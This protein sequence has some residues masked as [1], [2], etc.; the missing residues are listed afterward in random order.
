M[1]AE[2]RPTLLSVRDLKTYFIQDEGTVKAVDGVSF[3]LYPGATL[4]IVGESGC[5]KSVTARSILGIVDRPGRIVSGEIRFRRQA[6]ARTAEPAV[7]LAKLAPDGPEIRAIRGA[8]IAL[9]FQEPMSSFSPVHTIGSQIVEVIMLHQRINRGEARQKAIEILRRVGVSSPEQRVDQ[10]SNQLSGGLRQRAMIAMALSCHPT[11]LIADEPTTA[12]DVTTQTQILELLRQLQRE[13]G[14]A[15]MLI[16]HD[17]G[18]V[19]EMATDVAV[20]YLGRVVEQGTVDQIFHDPEAPVYPGPPPVHPPHALEIAGAADAHRGRGAAPLRPAERLP[21]PPAL[22]GVHGGALRQGGA[23]AAAGRGQARGQLLPLPVNALAPEVLLRVTGLQKLF[24]IRKGFLRRT[25]G[26]VR[27]VD[28]VDFHIDEGETLGL[29]GES[30]CGK[31]TTARCIMRA[32]E[33]TGGEILMRVTDGSVVEVGRLG[34]K[35]LRALRREMQMIFQ[36]PFS[37]LNPRM[38]LLDLVGE[39]LLVHGMK[40]R[41]EREDRVADLLRRVG[42]RPEYMRR[43]PHAF[44]GGER[45]RIGIARALALKPRLVVADEPVSA[46]DVSVQAQILNLL[47]DL[48]GSSG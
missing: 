45:Q 30:G 26:H 28:G 5:G 44:S 40:S 46:L 22:S 32:I 38:T 2:A 27:A 33:P 18:V 48:Q 4:G 13:D 31:T 47:Q 35:E 11:L 3:D 8:E 17:L 7:D 39:P 14:M 20:M 24:P 15:I 41:R 43:Y 23:D 16:T 37:S 29:V 12:L 36:D 1:A 6:A 42:L 10:L 34:R 19:A 9:I 25:V 21:L